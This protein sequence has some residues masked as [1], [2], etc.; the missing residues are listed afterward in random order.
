MTPSARAAASSISRARLTCDLVNQADGVDFSKKAKGGK[1][2]REDQPR[3]KKK[4]Q[5][6]KVR[7]LD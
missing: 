3:V 1:E 2:G 5:P 4:A 6:C 7:F